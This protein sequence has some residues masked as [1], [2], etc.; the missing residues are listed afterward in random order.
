MFRKPPTPKPKRRKNAVPEDTRVEKADEDW[1]CTQECEE[2]I[3]D[4]KLLYSKS[5]MFSF[6]LHEGFR[7]AIRENNGEKLMMYHRVHTP[8]LENHHHWQYVKNFHRLLALEGGCGSEYVQNSIKWNSTV[9]VRGTRGGNIAMGM[10]MLVV[11][12]PVIVIRT[13]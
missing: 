9:N 1:F 11:N 7:T 12:I 3:Q 5:V 13:V 2:D 10:A 6:L 4:R 8:M